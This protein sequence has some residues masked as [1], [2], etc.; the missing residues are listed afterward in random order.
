VD[1]SSV[2]CQELCRELGHDFRPQALADEETED[3][4][5]ARLQQR[6]DAVARQAA[7]GVV[8]VRLEDA[9]QWVARAWA[10]DALRKAGQASEP[11][12]Q[13]RERQALLQPE[14]TEPEGHLAPP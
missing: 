2:R 13:E 4:A 12:V 7:E 5:R 9:G 3:A 11:R 8:A 10:K 6:P 1:R 14:Q